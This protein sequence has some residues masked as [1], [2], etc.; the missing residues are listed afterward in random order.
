MAVEIL[1]FRITGMSPILMNNPSC[2]TPTESN[3][4]A[5]K[6]TYSD[7]EE[8]DKRLYKNK[9]GE[10]YI[11]PDCFRSAIIGKG[12]SASGRKI[13]KVSAVSIMSAGFFVHGTE[14]VLEHPKTKKVLTTYSGI[15]KRRVVVNKNGVIRARPRIDDWACTLVCEID[16]DFI[17]K[18][19][20]VLELLNIAG[21]YPGVLDFRPGRNGIFGR[22]K[23]EIAA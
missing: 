1:K 5:K 22:F 17:G 23:A 14:C 6:K 7:D 19:S 20:L 18:S 12:G 21:K 3:L 16:T 2:M 4:G 10:L 9:K 11:N 15:D 8:A 13:G